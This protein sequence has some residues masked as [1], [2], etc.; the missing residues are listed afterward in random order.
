[1]KKVLML[2]ISVETQALGPEQGGGDLII[3]RGTEGEV[4]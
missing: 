2:R 1:M 3:G 4:R